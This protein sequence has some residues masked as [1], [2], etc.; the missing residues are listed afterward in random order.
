MHAVH[1][2][3]PLSSA[4]LLHTLDM[5][6][7]EHAG[8]FVWLLAARVC[9]QEIQ[10]NE[11]AGVLHAGTQLVYLTQVLRL[12]FLLSSAYHTHSTFQCP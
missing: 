9:V 12:C 3:G 10:E 5:G 8:L 2:L 6:E 1:L 11:R 4:A 7:R